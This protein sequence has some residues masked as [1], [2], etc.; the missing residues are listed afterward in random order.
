MRQVTYVA[1]PETLRGEDH[2]KDMDIDGRI[3]LR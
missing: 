1:N 3:I 2:L